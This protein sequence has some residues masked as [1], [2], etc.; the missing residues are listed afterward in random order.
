MKERDQRGNQLLG[1]IGGGRKIASHRLSEK[2]VVQN[3][4]C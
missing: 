1:K 2:M 3:N 4:S